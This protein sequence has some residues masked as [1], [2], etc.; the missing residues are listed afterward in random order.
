[1]PEKTLPIP[2]EAF[3]APGTSLYWLGGGGALI[4]S[5]GTS[6]MIDPV[7]EGFDMPLLIDQPLTPEG[8]PSLDALLSRF[9]TPEAL[10]GHIAGLTGLAPT[11]DPATPEELLETFDLA[12]LPDALAD[13]VQILWR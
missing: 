2:P 5:R 11:G 7:L 12:A 4:V 8:V 1:M 6:I 9:K 10:L 3:S 13:P